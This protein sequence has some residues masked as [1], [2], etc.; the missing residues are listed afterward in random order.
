MPEPHIRRMA[1]TEGVARFVE[2]LLENGAVI[3]EDFLDADVLGRFNDELTPLLAQQAPQREFINEA[4][5]GFFGD[6]TRHLTALAAKSDS[7]VNDILCHPL[8]FGIG[9][10]ILRPSCAAMQLNLGHIIDRGPGGHAQPLHR[11][12]E[13]WP[14][15]GPE[16]PQRM[17]ASILALGEFTAEMGATFVTCETVWA[18]RGGGAV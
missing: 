3:A 12:E 7:F 17:F 2:Q 5:A 13:I 15:T 10:A 1:A 14:R 16:T 8:Y 18:G 9:D 4:V 11:D 6:R